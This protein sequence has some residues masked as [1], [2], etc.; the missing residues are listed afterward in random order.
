MGCSVVDRTCVLRR[1][2]RYLDCGTTSPLGYFNIFVN[3][4]RDIL[5]Q[6]VNIATIIFLTVFETVLFI[7][8]L[9]S[10]FY[11]NTCQPFL[12]PLFCIA[13]YEMS[14]IL[15]TPYKVSPIL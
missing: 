1:G 7:F 15:Q 8:T 5:P 4:Y 3:P 10:L 14:L 2:V 12:S 6:S 9:S 11:V 13:P